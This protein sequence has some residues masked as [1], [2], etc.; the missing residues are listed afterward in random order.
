[1]RSRLLL[2]DDSV[3]MRK[4]IASHLQQ[5]GYEVETACDGHEGLE[6]A[7]AWSPELIV[8]D[9]EMPGLDGPGLCRALKADRDLRAIPVIMLTSLGATESKVHGLDSGAD[10]YIE[11]PKSPADI[12]EIFA[13]IRAQLRIADLRRELA[14]RNRRLEAAQAQM[15]LELKLARKVQMGLM[16]RPPRPRGALRL[17]VYYQPANELGGDVYEF[18]VLD[19]GRLGVV[20][21]DISG[22]GVNAALLSG[23]VKTLVAPLMAA[24]SSPARV[25]ADLDTAVGQYFPDEYFC[26]AFALTIDEA[27]G[28]FVYAGVGHPPALLVG[29][30]GAIQLDSEPGLLGL[31]MAGGLTDGTGRL[32]P[33]ESLLIY[34]DGLPDAMDPDDRQFGTERIRS[35]LEAHRADEPAAI[36][37]R[38]ERAVALHVAPGH[39]HDD[40]NMILIQNRGPAPE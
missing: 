1:M 38:I 21:A 39:P 32:G 4:M 5:E 15:D 12:Q 29:P 31:D 13:R 35:A 27:T 9:F 36:I 22:H 37:E 11:K 19:G 23:M 10:D 8:T 18:A 24:D 14:E 33:G 6:K 3:M 2:V 28:E 40:I 7:L 34:T 25:L 17:E 16:P 20:A 30:S 26:T